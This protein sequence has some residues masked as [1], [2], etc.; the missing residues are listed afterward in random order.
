MKPFSP[1][2]RPV[3][4]D[5]DIWH[6][7]FS[8]NDYQIPELSSSDVVIDVGAHIGAFTCACLARGAQRVI[9][10]EP[11]A[12]SFLLAG[13]NIRDYL[14]SHHFARCPVLHNAAVWRS[15]RQESLQITNARFNSLIHAFHHAAQCTLFHDAH[16]MPVHSVGLDTVLQPLSEVA[17][18]KLDCEGAEWPI[19]F[20]STQLYKVRRLVLEVH[21]LAWKAAESGREFSSSLFDE[22]GRYTVE[23]LKALLRKAGLTCTRE[24]INHNYL[25]NSAFYFGLLAFERTTDL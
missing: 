2:C 24:R 21:S 16:T 13:Q 14:A 15:D 18:L 22:F 5:S 3:S 6:E 4:S 20:T 12:S 17:L 9:A 11:D 19:I 8:C 23:D 7:V 1:V 10:F 25:N